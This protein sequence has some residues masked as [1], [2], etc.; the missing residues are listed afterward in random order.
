MKNQCDIGWNSGSMMTDALRFS[1]PLCISKM[2]LIMIS[3][4]VLWL[5]LLTRHRRTLRDVV[6]GDDDFFF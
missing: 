4:V 2:D 3:A 1:Q 5:K 6:F